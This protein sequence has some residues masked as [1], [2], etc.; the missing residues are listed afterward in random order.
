MKNKTAKIH[1]NKHIKSLRKKG[2]I[3][4][5]LTS[6]VKNNESDTT[7]SVVK[8]G[9]TFKKQDEY[10][11][12]HDNI[13]V[14]SNRNKS[15]KSIGIIH[16]TDSTAVNFVRQG[17]TNVAN[18]FGR[19][20]FDNTI[21]DNLRNSGLEKLKQQ[22]NSDQKVCSLRMDFENTLEGT[23][24]IHIYGTLLQKVAAK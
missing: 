4:W 10:I 21:Y 2:G 3:L 24:F 15:Y 6:T 22:I 7:D 18:I 19:K 13:T 17:A 14:E 12:L 5:P 1:K 20:G 8:N 11:F 9:S 23:I 16:I